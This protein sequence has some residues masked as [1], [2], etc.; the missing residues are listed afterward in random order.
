MCDEIINAL[1]ELDKNP[2]S[3][4]LHP[5]SVIEPEQRV[6]CVNVPMVKRHGDSFFYAD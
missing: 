2:D 3:D 6:Q 5:Y 4:I 1:I